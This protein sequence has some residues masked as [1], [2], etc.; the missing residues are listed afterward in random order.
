MRYIRKIVAILLIL[1]FIISFCGCDSETSEENKNSENTGGT[2]DTHILDIPYSRE[3]GMNPYLAKSFINSSI[4]QLVY[5]GLYSVDNAYQAQPVL[6]SGASIDGVEVVVD[7]G[8]SRR[9]SDGSQITADDVIYSF[10]MAKSSVY[11]GSSLQWIDSVSAAS[12]K[13]VIFHL[14]N[15]N[16]YILSCL[17]FPVVKLNTA[18]EQSSKPVGAGMYVYSDKD[19]GG[20]LNRNKYYSSEQYSS[21]NVNLVNVSDDKSL[22]YSLVIGNIDAVFDDLSDGESQ[23]INASSIQVPLNNLIFLGVSDRGIMSDV[24]LRQYISALLNRDDLISSGFEGYG[25]SSDRPFHP[26]WYAANGIKSPKYDYDDANDYIKSNYSNDSI[27]ILV[28]SGN[29]FKVKLADTL[30]S[31]LEDMGIKSE[32]NAVETA[33]YNSAVASGKYD[34]YIGEYKLANDMNINGIIKYK[35][36]GETYAEFLSGNINCDEFM[37]LFSEKQPFIPIG[38]RNGILA[39]SRNLEMTVEPTPE[40]PFANLSEWVI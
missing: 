30:R 19:N 1:C 10:K 39:Y 37:T 31:Q 18:N 22:L 27:T 34:I 6:A 4:M 28:N 23:R 24:K 9:F 13:T 15:P 26:T 40:F 36:L 3:D 32:V 29:N 2:T 14:K 7:I 11:Y 12:V 5:S 25:V 17:T 20:E 16:Q 33:A 38:F 21:E 8:A 35:D